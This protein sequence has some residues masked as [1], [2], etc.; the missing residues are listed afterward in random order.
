MAGVA[1]NSAIL[2]KRPVHVVR[3]AIELTVFKPP[4]DR[5][6]MRQ[7]MGIAPKDLMLLF[8][9]FDLV[10]RRKGVALL[11]E[12]LA[13]LAE[14]G[15][16]AAAL[17][18]G[19]RVHVGMFGK[20]PLPEEIPGA[21]LVQFG[22]VTDDAVLA[23]IYGAADVVCLPSLEDNYPN[24]IVEAFACGTPC[25]GY[26]AGGMAEM[27]E[28]GVTGVLV[29]E[30]GSVAALQA[31][32]VRFAKQHFRSATMRTA[33]RASAKRNNGPGRVGRQ[34][35]ALYEGAL[36]RPL[37]AADPVLRKRIVRT[38]AN[39]PVPLDVHAGGDLLQFPLNMAVIDMAGRSPQAAKFATSQRSQA[40][41]QHRLISVHTFHDHHSGRSGPY[42]FLRHLPPDRYLAKHM[43]VPLGTQLAGDRADLCRR[44]GALMGVTSFGR[45]GNA[46]QAEAEVLMLCAREPVDLVHFID[47]ELGGWLLAG[48]PDSI[49]DGGRRPAMVAT[50]HQPEQLLRGMINAD[51]IRR[52]DGVIALCKTQGD[53]LLNYVAPERLFLVPHGIDSSF[54]RLPGP[55]H[56]APPRNAFR[57]LLVGH[58]LRDIKAVL[59]AFTALAA[60]MATE[61]VIIA[62]NFPPIRPDPRIT[63]LSG[64]SDEALREAYWDADLLVLPLRDATANNA[65][66]EAM[67]CGLPV[68]STDVGGVRECTSDAAVLCPPNDPDSIVGAVLQLAR[69]AERRAMMRAQGRARAEQLDWSIIGQAH[70]RI[71][72]TLLLRS[73]QVPL[74]CA[75]APPAAATRPS[76]SMILNYGLA[77]STDLPSSDPDRDPPAG[78]RASPPAQVRSRATRAAKRRSK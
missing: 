42:Q 66:L 40:A 70:D 54:F 52:F 12:A 72:Q 20:S 59:A 34:L 60:E 17:G 4:A 50:F 7:A 41:G 10:E 51:L 14:D 71:Y 36:G 28:D 2:G 35:R 22:H 49:F 1:R 56:A 57:L 16:L 43:L 62:P 47:G 39:A 23:D 74:E 24:V 33:C 27:I 55:D 63:I 38:M 68:V 75:Q 21:L 53:F 46:W 3:N 65:I 31:G 30:V 6:A 8:G 58:W 19:A 78:K 77:W 76:R 73:R 9:S 15:R 69:D 18:Q 26:S 11:I 64:L 5:V 29:P 45:Q 61:L 48:M 32:L 44:A 37:V 25:V 67:A 13:G